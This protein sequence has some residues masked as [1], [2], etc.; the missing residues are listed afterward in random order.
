MSQTVDVHFVEQFEAE[1]HLAYQRMGAM[2]RN[3]TRRKDNIEGKQTSFRKTAATVAGTKSRDGKVPIANLVHT[4]VDCVLSDHYIGE[5]IDA[6]DQLKT[7]IDEMDVASMSLAASLGRKS[8]EL[9][10]DDGLANSSQQTATSGGVTKAKIELIYEAFG[11]DN[12]PAD[13]RRFL[14]VSAQGWTDL[15]NLDEFARVEFIGADRLPWANPIGAKS[16]MSFI[17]F[18][19]SGWSAAGAVRSGY[20]WHASAVG[21]ASGKEVGLDISWDGSRQS[22]LVVGSMSQGACEIDDLGKYELRHTEV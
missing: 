2:L 13:G 11:N 10:R 3:T 18:E 21:H 20:A 9:I 5:Y 4:E 16:W 12:V 7:N 1:V 6:L 8:D 15:M 19:Y 17:V 14:S 22:N